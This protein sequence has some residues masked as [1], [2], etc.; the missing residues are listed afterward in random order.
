M[1]K[2]YLTTVLIFGLTTMAQASQVTVEFNYEVGIKL[3]H[4]ESIAIPLDEIFGS[5]YITFENITMATYIYDDRV[6]TDFNIH[7]YDRAVDLDA[8]MPSNPYQSNPHSSNF[9]NARHTTKNHSDYLVESS[10]LVKNYLW[11]DP[12]NIANLIQEYSELQISVFYPSGHLYTVTPEEHFALW[13]SQIGETA[14]YSAFYNVYI[15]SEYDTQLNW[16]AAATIT[17]VYEGPHQLT[18][19]PEPCTMLLLG[20]GLAGIVICTRKRKNQI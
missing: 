14:L 16:F 15:D 18:P 10:A 8:F 19:V 11:N 17:D 1:K 6:L 7:D 3:D 12:E 5:G 20:T 13:E 2:L 9:K 4:L